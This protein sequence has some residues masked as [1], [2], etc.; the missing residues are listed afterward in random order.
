MYRHLA[1]R[2]TM[3]NGI[4]NSYLYLSLFVLS[5]EVERLDGWQEWIVSW[6][7]IFSAWPSSS[8]CSQLTAPGTH[9]HT[10]LTCTHRHTYLTCD[11]SQSFYCHAVSFHSPISC[12]F[13]CPFPFFRYMYQTSPFFPLDSCPVLWSRSILARLQ[14]VKMVAPAPALA[15]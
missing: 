15:L 1:I 4:K 3:I 9:R 13:S 8:S 10:Y 12:F 14:L 5:E 7:R 2:K 11:S 6:M